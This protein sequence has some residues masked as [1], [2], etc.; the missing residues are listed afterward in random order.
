[1]WM[2]TAALRPDLKVLTTCRESEQANGA[3][4]N[5]QLLTFNNRG[6]SRGQGTHG[7]VTVAVLLH[8]VCPRGASEVSKCPRL[9]DPVEFQGH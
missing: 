5:L 7:N 1:M 8:R 4:S 2:G 9:L 3:K 6:Q